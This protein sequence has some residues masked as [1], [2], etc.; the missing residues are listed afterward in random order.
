[1][2]IERYLERPRQILGGRVFVDTTATIV[3]LWARELL[4]PACHQKIVEEALRRGLD[5]SRLKKLG[6][7]CGR[8]GPRGSVI[9]G[10]RTVSFIAEDGRHENFYFWR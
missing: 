3:P 7:M 5:K 1:V 6:E 10:G 9:V 8:R 4:D 2:L